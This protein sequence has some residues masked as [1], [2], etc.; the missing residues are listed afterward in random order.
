MMICLRLEGVGVRA[1]GQ[2][3][4]SE[5]WSIKARREV[6]SVPK[7]LAERMVS[8]AFSWRARGVYLVRFCCSALAR[9]LRGCWWLA[10]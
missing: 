8:L 9:V 6:E 5:I 3:A 1:I 4:V 2:G 10:R 7:R